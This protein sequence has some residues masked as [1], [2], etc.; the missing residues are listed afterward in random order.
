LGKR[1]L[2]SGKHDSFFSCL[3]FLLLVGA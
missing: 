2:L 1:K 3:R